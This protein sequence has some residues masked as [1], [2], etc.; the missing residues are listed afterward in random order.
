MKPILAAKYRPILAAFAHDRTLVAFDF[1]GTLAPI[2]SRPADA[3]MRASTVRLLSIVARRYPCVIVTGRS[4]RDVT[5]R[6]HGAPVEIVGNHGA[7][8]QAKG[9]DVRRVIARAK[10][11]VTPIVK[12]WPGAWVEDKIYSL[13]VHYRQAEEAPA[14][15]AAVNRLGR[16]LPG[17]R[18]VPGKLVMNLVA[19][20][21][22]DK[23]IA[24]EAAR[25]RHDCR[26][27]IFVGDD[28]TDESVFREARPS[29][30]LGVRVGPY[31]NTRA[32]FGLRRQE[33]IDRLLAALVR[34]RP[35]APA[36]GS[37]KRRTDE[38]RLGPTLE[39]M[40]LLWGLDHAL[41]RRSKWLASKRGVTGPQ[42]LA[43][44]IVGHMPHVSAGLLATTLKLHPSTLTGVLQRLE[45]R[46]FLTRR[47]DGSDRRRVHLDLTDRGRGATRPLR[48][49][50]EDAVTQVLGREDP[51]EVRATA[52]LLRSLVRELEAGI[53]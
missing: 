32:G 6:L 39:F 8:P 38:S 21:A 16:R 13:S 11:A 50:V 30:L 34:L 41:Q 9:V 26:R 37:H 22:P 35:I 2:A 44:R 5:E 7:E 36:A 46:G 1:D 10:R 45:R 52:D 43:L 48:G 51:R 47:I 28:Y 40:R 17:I 14:S 24:V 49:S 31:E 15:V 3:A 33:E 25:R 20:G 27:V 18:V 12:R 29:R 23:G 53:T 42:R 19:R 4:L